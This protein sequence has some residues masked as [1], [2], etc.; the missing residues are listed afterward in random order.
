MSP[1]QTEESMADLVTSR[2]VE[3]FLSTGRWSRHLAGEIGP[4]SDKSL[5]QAEVEHTLV[6]H[7]LKDAL[8]SEVR[9]RS[10]ERAARRR[11]DVLSKRGGTTPSGQTETPA[12]PIESSAVV[13][14]RVEP[15]VAGLFPSDERAPVISALQ[16]SFV[17]VTHDTVEDA[18]RSEPSLETAWHIANMYLGSIGAESL[19]GGLSDIG[20]I[21]E[22]TICY[23][24]ADC[25]QH[26][27]PFADFVVHEAAHL[28]HKKKRCALG[29]A[30]A[31]PQATLLP[32]DHRK[33]EVFAYS[34]EA[35]AGMA[36]RADH[37]SDRD[38]RTHL[39]DE[40]V[41]RHLPS[42]R[43]VD[44][45]AL[46]ATLAEAVSAPNG[47]GVILARCAERTL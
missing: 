3:R 15:M 31:S 7:T 37:P 10:E 20:G 46:T 16:S 47:W 2:A 19:D 13:R 26:E 38:D 36:V 41:E 34:C 11:R 42:P 39:Y 4:G 17:F 18:I 22:K 40:Y 24:A 32:I 21:S 14:K 35:Y 8:V 25:F 44:R 43:W 45:D 28:L 6:E 30:H 9:F 29:L 33:R 27:D 12:G 5:D 1:H 23:V